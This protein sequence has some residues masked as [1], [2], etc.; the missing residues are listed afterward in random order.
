MNKAKIIIS[1]SLGWIIFVGYLTWYNGL[2]ASGTYK[3]FNWEEWFWF[4]VLPSTAPYFF[5]FI[6]KPKYL[7][8]FINCI[9]S[10]FK[11]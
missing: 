5:L 2:K 4:G 11:D 9:K 7:K 1:L 10:L 6:W 8:D 3:G